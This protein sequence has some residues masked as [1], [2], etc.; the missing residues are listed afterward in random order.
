MSEFDTVKEGTSVEVRKLEEEDDFD[1]F[2]A[3]AASSVA[4]QKLEEELH[5]YE[6]LENDPFDTSI[7]NNIL[8]EDKAGMCKFLKKNSK[9]NFSIIIGNRFYWAFH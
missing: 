7:V 2:T 8:K 3:L 5:I 4:N 1:E 9:C 6:D